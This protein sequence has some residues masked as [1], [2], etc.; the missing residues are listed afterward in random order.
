[1]DKTQ[2]QQKIREYYLKLPASAQASFSSLTWVE[3]LNGVFSK[4]LI[5]SED[6]KQEIITETMLVLLGIIHLEEY[7]NKILNG[8]GV[9]KEVSYK[10]LVDIDKAIL[11]DLRNDLTEVFNKNVAEAT[12]EDGDGKESEEI[13]H[14]DLLENINFITSGGKNT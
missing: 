5:L 8:L 11:V 4:Y 3:T 1:M 9:E 13:Y 7:E 10:I 2:L 6:Q 12:E 14:K